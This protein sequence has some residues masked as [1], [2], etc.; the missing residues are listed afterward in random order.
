M[1]K[2]IEGR[3]FFTKQISGG[4]NAKTKRFLKGFMARTVNSIGRTVSYTSTKAY[5]A[6]FLSFGLMTLFL[7]LGKYYILDNPTVESSSLVIGAIFAFL[8]IPLMFFDKPMCI[9]TQDFFVTDYLLYDF[10]FIKKL[11]KLQNPPSI[12]VVLAVFIGFIPAFL[13]FVIPITY[14]LIGILVATVFFMSFT[15]PE[16][17]LILTILIL[18]YTSFI[19][20]NDYILAAM[21]LVVFVSYIFRVILG[22][23]VFYFDIYSI[24]VLIFAVFFAVSGFLG[25]GDDSF[26]NTVIFLLLI[27]SYYPANS[28]IVNRRLADAAVKA[29]VFSSLPI[30][31]YVIVRSA[32]DFVKSGLDGVFKFYYGSSFGGEGYFLVGAYLLISAI[33]TMMFFLQKKQRIKKSFYAVFF[34]LNILAIAFSSQIGAVISAIF[35]IILALFLFSKRISSNFFF[36]ISLIPYFIPLIPGRYLE[37]VSEF[38]RIEPSINATV[39]KISQN[40]SVFLANFFIGVGIGQDSFD[41]FMGTGGSTADNLFLGIGTSVGVFAL[42]AFFVLLAV[43]YL[44]AAMH[45][46]YVKNS[47][48]N[49]VGIMSTLALSSLIMYGAFGNLFNR[50]EL[51]Y[52]FFIIFAISTT[53]L[54]DAKQEYVDRV[55]YYDDLR[56]SE[57]SSIDINLQ[58]R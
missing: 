13:G 11:H 6:L 42:A 34:A 20:Y 44:H 30:S 19:P 49:I 22:K 48:M 10:F 23:R 8:G 14:V 12:P 52:I 1:N 29:I 25:Y 15:S 26:K 47:S 53:S 21:S 40:L 24:L 45:R 33:F 5:G 27:L 3:L 41:A 37:S 18:P 38:L 57:A 51:F 50:I 36:P 35:G 46:V 39:E 55:G 32:I 31:V 54:R 4:N 28:L 43:N 58:V 17:S 7:N 9:A 2:T 16:F 56:S